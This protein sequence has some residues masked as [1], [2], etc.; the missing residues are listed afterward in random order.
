MSA[1]GV[2]AD[3]V[4][5][6]PGRENMRSVSRASFPDRALGDD[7]LDA[8]AD[9][10]VAWYGMRRA[11]GSFRGWPFQEPRFRLWGFP[12]S[13]AAA[14]R[15]ELF[16]R[17]NRAGFHKA[18]VE[19]ADSDT[20]VLLLDPTP[21]N[22]PGTRK[23]L[24]T[25]FQGPPFDGLVLMARLRIC[26]RERYPHAEQ[27]PYGEHALV[28]VGHLREGRFLLKALW[29]AGEADAPERLHEL[30]A[31]PMESRCLQAL[32]IFL[33][34][35]RPDA[36]F[37]MPF[38]STLQGRLIG[39]LARLIV[40]LPGDNKVRLFLGR[41]GVFVG[42]T[43]AS[44]YGV[45]IG[46][47]VREGWGIA[48]PLLCMVGLAGLV[49]A[50]WRK[51]QNIALRYR[52]MKAA[53]KASYS[54]P[55]TFPRTDL[56]AACVARD[57]ALVKFSADLQDAGC[58]P[59]FDSKSAAAN[60]TTYIR[61]YLLPADR[62]Y[63]V[64]NL[65]FR[66]AS[67]QKFPAMAHLLIQTFFTDG[68]RLVSVNSRASGHRKP[69]APALTFRQYPDFDFAELIARHRSVLQ[70]LQVEGHQVAP[71]LSPDAFVDR[72]AE[73]H[74]KAAER[75]TKYGYYSWSAAIRQSFGWARR[76]YQE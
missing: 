11:S 68:H 31:W 22:E 76:E 43:A 71:T 2:V 47:G 34:T 9:L 57:P 33:V 10:W 65:M 61:F 37:V 48:P 15:E 38:S 19:L 74:R 73:E 16:R 13:R 3:Y 54:R 17:V 67:F 60:S 63:V 51:G 7:E 1:V 24:S 72:L 66:T 27:K 8:L 55:V 4:L 28:L 53:L 62:T 41:V 50:L 39:A 59:F 20:L 26:R 58:I 32:D 6:W 5:K 35:R 36:L 21:L 56:A 64:L 30:A 18:R 69:T 25:L 29:P 45:A 75:A 46:V 14:V 49:N 70:R 23:V 42:L 12:R 40:D 44:A 52:G